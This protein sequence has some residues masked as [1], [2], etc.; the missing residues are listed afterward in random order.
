MC[1]H[2]EL[3][4]RPEICSEYHSYLN[5][6]IYTSHLRLLGQGIKDGT[7]DWAGGTHAES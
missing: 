7:L 1:L 6:V 5:F 3:E 4:L 2:A